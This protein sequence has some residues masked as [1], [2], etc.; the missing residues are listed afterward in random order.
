LTSA[1]HPKCTVFVSSLYLV[2]ASF[3]YI[4]SD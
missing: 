3:I 2:A 1:V 4:C